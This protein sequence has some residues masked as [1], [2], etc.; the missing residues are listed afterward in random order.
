MMGMIINIVILMIIGTVIEILQFKIGEKIRVK[1]F[2]KVN[3]V[4]EYTKEIMCIVK[5]IIEK[6]KKVL[7]KK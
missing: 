4:Y 2:G 6:M 7:W 1:K 3:K 5:E